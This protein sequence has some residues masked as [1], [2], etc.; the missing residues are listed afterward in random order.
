MQKI[1]K[2]RGDR[3]LRKQLAALNKEI[4]EHALELT[5]Q[6][7]GNI[8]D[9]MD[10]EI[11]SAR[12][13]RLLRHLLDPEKTKSEARQQLQKLVYKYE[14]PTKKLLTEVNDRYLSCAGVESLPK[15]A[16][17]ENPDLD[18]PITVAE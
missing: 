2:K 13:W 3:N 17:S 7:W 10:T 6:N 14:G 12:T 11:S 15:Y 4:E 5:K 18:S 9:Q 16:G 1:S 8:C